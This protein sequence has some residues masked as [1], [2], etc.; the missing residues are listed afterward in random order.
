VHVRGSLLSLSFLFFKVLM[1][2]IR[3]RSGLGLP[4]YSFPLSFLFSP[5]PFLVLRGRG[6]CAGWEAVRTEIGLLSP[7]R[8]PPPLVKKKFPR[9]L[10]GTLAEF[11][12]RMVITTFDAE[13]RLSFFFL[14]FSPSELPLFFS[15]LLLAPLLM[16]ASEF[17]AGRKALADSYKEKEA[18]PAHPVPPPCFFSPFFFFFPFL[19]AP[20]FLFSFSF[21]GSELTKRIIRREGKKLW[22][23]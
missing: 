17:V 10:L 23:T 7:F 15:F 11:A 9:R 1:R 2:A 12:M 8:F 3:S 4:S 21:F 19:G 16:L 5:L 18:V 20:L 22:Q 6:R 13:S 14:P